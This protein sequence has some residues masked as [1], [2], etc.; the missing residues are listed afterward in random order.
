MNVPREILVPYNKRAMLFI[1]HD[2]AKFLLKQHYSTNI[3]THELVAL[4]V[5]KGIRHEK[6]NYY[7]VWHRSDILISQRKFLLFVC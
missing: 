2:R 7:G 4:G 1:V 3:H 5:K 6:L